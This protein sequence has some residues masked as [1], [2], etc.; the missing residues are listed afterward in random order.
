MI[1]KYMNMQPTDIIMLIELW[2]LT[3]TIL[4]ASVLGRLTKTKY[5][6]K[7]GFLEGSKLGPYLRVRKIQ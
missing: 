5:L 7:Q 3:V 2:G 1:C 4:L 6:K